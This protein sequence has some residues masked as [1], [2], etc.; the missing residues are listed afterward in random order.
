ML[1]LKR[2]RKKE[3]GREGG[4]YKGDAVDALILQAL[5]DDARVPGALV[6]VLAV[7]QDL[8]KEGGREG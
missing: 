4:T 1:R 7:D 3:G 8:G 5:V 6:L 2:E